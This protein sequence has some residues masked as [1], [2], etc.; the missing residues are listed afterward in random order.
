MPKFGFRKLVRDRL[1]ELYVELH[2]KAEIRSV[3][4]DELWQELKRKFI[5]EASELPE[6]TNDTAVLTSELADL[7]RV[8]KD[9]ATHLGIAF[10]DIE[11]ADAAKTAKK[12]GFLEGA[13]VETLETEEN[14]P[15]NDYYR[16]EPRRFPE[17]NDSLDIPEIIELSENLAELGKIDRRTLLPGGRNES[18]SHHSFSLALT[19]YDI[20]QKYCPELD[21]N[22]VVRY[23]LVHDLLEIILGDEDTL[24]S[25][26]AELHAKHQREQ[27]AWHELEN[28]LR[29]YPS[30]LSGLKEYEALD[31]PEAATVYVLDKTCTIW[32]HFWDS[33]ESLH[34]RGAASRDDI[35]IWYKTQQDKLQKRLKVMPPQIVLDIFA[36]SY[37]KMRKE[38]FQS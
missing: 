11:Q 22:L 32:T 17:L 28:K 26:A 25:T 23:A 8:L 21:C 18:D 14:D 16:K 24:Q 1:P 27:A 4:G 19:A 34:S 36:D 12:G 13:Y 2:Q 35:D 10:T 7:L 37:G 31:T 15:W 30:L 29:K 9:S 3:D 33:G 38:L 5:E 6:A 20:C